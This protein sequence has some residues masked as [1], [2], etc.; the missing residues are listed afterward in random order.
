MRNREPDEKVKGRWRKSF[1]DN[2]KL[3]VLFL[4]IAAGVLT[5]L[6]NVP[7]YLSDR[8]KRNEA[9][10]FGPCGLKPQTPPNAAR[11]NGY[12]QEGERYQAAGEYDLAEHRFQQVIDADP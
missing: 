1:T 11:L 12:I 7:K 5:L 10:S 3:V 4:T 2:G 6:S 9:K 8:Q